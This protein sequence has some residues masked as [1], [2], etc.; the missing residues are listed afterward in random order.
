M[1][2]QMKG[3]E[4]E[5]E[6]TS[7]RGNLWREHYKAWKTDLKQQG[8]IRSQQEKLSEIRQVGTAAILVCL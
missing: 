6:E 1:D 3:D 8:T 2:G 5:L 7:N 4:E